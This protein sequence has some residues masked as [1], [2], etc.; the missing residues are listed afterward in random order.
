MPSIPDSHRDL[1]ESQVATLATIGP[2]GRPQ[3]SEVWFVVDGD[4]L[5]VSL[6]SS[7]QKTKNLVVNPACTLFLLDLSAPSRYLE[8]R[9]DAELVPDPD[10][11][12]A[13]AVNAKYD[14]D[15]SAHDGPDDSRVMVRIHPVRINAVD[16][17]A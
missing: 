12:L 1:L 7:R 3:L 8:V 16:M 6:N 5:E 15:V 10:Y 17:Q 11:K 9:G 4:T 13:A 14:S 2:D